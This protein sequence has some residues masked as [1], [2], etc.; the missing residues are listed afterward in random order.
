MPQGLTL[1][2]GKL[3][4]V[5][6]MATEATEGR[7]LLESEMQASECVACAIR[8]RKHVVNFRAGG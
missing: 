6:Q 2:V 7:R 8:N 4:Q 5:E 3:E 1:G